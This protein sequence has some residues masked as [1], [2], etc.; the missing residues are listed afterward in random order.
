M[1]SKFPTVKIVILTMHNK[2]MFIREAFE[3]GAHGYILK[4]GDFEKMIRTVRQVA[5][6]NTSRG[7]KP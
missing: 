1:A 6:G 5:E 4:D 2:E 3:A 7:I